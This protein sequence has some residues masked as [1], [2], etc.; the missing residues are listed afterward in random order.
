[1]KVRPSLHELQRLPLEFHFTPMC[2]AM[3]WV[4]YGKTSWNGPSKGSTRELCSNLAHFKDED[5]FVCSRHVRKKN[6]RLKVR[7]FV[8]CEGGYDTGLITP[9]EI[10]RPLLENKSG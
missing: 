9:V 3:A 5:R 4:P 8:E 6:T 10:E 2:E 7:L 1:M